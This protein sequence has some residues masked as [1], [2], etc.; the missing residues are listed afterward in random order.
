VT[1]VSA[2][3]TTS[4]HLAIITEHHRQRSVLRLRGELDAANEDHLRCAIRAVLNQHGPHDLVLDL[5]ELGFTDCAGLS[6]ILWAHKQL[7]GR[8]HELVLTDIQPFVR[9]LLNVTGLNI[10][11]QSE[12]DGLTGA[13]APGCCRPYAYTICDQG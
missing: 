2:G 13:N 7:T 4:S 3:R 6:A 5:S 1:H 12:Q 11:L 9:R 10:Y 8:G